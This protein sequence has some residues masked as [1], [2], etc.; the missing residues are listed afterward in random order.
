MSFVVCLRNFDWETLDRAWEFTD[1]AIIIVSLNWKCG[2]D[3]E[4]GVL[5]RFGSSICNSFVTDLNL[6]SLSVSGL[7]K[8]ENSQT[9][10]R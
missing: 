10:C 5:Y 8:P 3:D 1:N 4:E 2:I 7:I 6:F 9:R